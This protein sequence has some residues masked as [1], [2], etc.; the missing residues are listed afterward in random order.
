MTRN[1]K[2]Y[3]NVFGFVKCFWFTKCIIFIT[4]TDTDKT[5]T[6]TLFVQGYLQT[7]L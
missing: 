3:V 7:A 2:C 5:Q 4:S 1:K 6:V